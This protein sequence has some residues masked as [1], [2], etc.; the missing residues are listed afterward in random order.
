MLARPFWA[1]VLLGASIVSIAGNARAQSTYD[2]SR[3]LALL[4]AQRA[5]NGIPAE[6]A[7]RDDWSA[8]CAKHSDYMRKT[9]TMEHSEDPSSPYYTPEGDQAARSSVL[10]GTWSMSLDT[11]AADPYA[12][13]PYETA[14]IHLM[15]LLGPGLAETGIAPDCTYTWPGY[16][17]PA[18]AAPQM[19]SYPG[20][21]TRGIYYS[22]RAAERPFVPGDK[23]GL[24]EG[25]TT[26]PHLMVLAWGVESG[27]LGD[28]ALVGPGGQV[29]VRTVDNETPQL[30]SYLPPG[31]M[32][33]P[34]KPLEPGASYTATGTFT[35]PAASGGDAVALPFRFTFTTRK[36]DPRTSVTLGSVFQV[37][38]D[39]P[40]EVSATVTR[41]SGEVIHNGPV[42][43]GLRL[44]RDIAGGRMEVCFRQPETVEFAAASGCADTT[45]HVA[46]PITLRSVSRRGRALAVRTSSVGL[47]FVISVRPCRGFNICSGTIAR[48]AVTIGGD[49][50][51]RIVLPGRAL[52]RA[53]LLR[54][55]IVRSADPST[56]EARWE[57]ASV[58][59]TVAK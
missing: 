42:H 30:G 14:P 10:G 53:R 41:P 11:S 18:P 37:D 24:P 4:N 28:V 16:T 8:N 12:S 49:S 52:R 15:Q 48:K 36:R 2:P 38:T 33:I 21:G 20:D 13:N 1:I 7:L 29:E 9:G 54:V 56:A 26:G 45:V 27:Q 59:R 3:A 51:L 57:R 25:T 47:R 22:E 5:F 46:A 17:R 44:G 43:A 6:I 58:V 50:L 32:L 19:L 39:S 23:V 55:T 40:G 34:V 31:G 35:G